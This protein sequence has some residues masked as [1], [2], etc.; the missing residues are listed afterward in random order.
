M[1]EAWDEGLYEGLGDALNRCLESCHVRLEVWNSVEFGNVGKTVVELQKKLEWLELQPST[2]Y[3]IRS[4]RNTRI[5]LNCWMDKEDDM[6][7]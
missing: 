6:W 4:L 2:L 7:R 1:K 3:M 5:E